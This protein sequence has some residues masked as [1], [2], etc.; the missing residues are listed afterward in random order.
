[1]KVIVEHTTPVSKLAFSPNGQILASSGIHDG[2]ILW[3]GLT[4]APLL[5][6]KV[7]AKDDIPLAFSP[8]NKIFASTSP[9][10]TLWVWGVKK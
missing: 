1:V 4:W 8:D 9:S 10:N 7:P 2:I 3:D 5:T 6:I